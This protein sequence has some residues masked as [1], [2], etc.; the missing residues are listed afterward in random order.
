M[1]ENPTIEQ[2]KTLKN[3]VY[4]IS[5]QITGQQYIGVTIQTFYGRYSSGKW[6]Q[7]SHNQ[8]LRRAASKY[9]VENFKIKILEYNVAS[10]EI[11]EELEIFY[12]WKFNTIKPNGYNLIAEWGYENLLEE[13]KEK[14]LR[15]S[16][17]IYKILNTETNKLIITDAPLRFCI[18]NN[19]NPHSFKS[20]MVRGYVS[21]FKLISRE[22]KPP[23]QKIRNLPITLK[24]V[25]TEEV[26]TFSCRRI[27]FNLT[28]CNSSDMTK[29]LNKEIK[30]CKGWC[31]PETTKEQLIKRE[32]TGYKTYT[33]ISPKGETII[34]TNL[35]KFCKENNMDY[36]SFMK[37]FR[38]RA[39]Y[40][41]WTI[42]KP[43]KIRKMVYKN[44]Q[45]LNNQ[46]GEILNFKNLRDIENSLKI[47]SYVIYKM[48]KNNKEY[49]GFSLKNIE[50]KY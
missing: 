18:N 16:P 11:L 17:Y 8:I 23:K 4:S 30:T 28:G 24:N 43:K 27:F 37:I 50:Y 22:N 35:P 48:A 7:F 20:F 21:H 31:L 2:L 5:N 14:M 45:L 36:R 6:W 40:K 33:L 12:I 49:K 32:R 25:Q 44:I 41:G 3:I 47:R 39:S 29:L 13:S 38:N 26:I 9:G 10:K 19:I 42:P 46:T 15:K 1:L 34:V